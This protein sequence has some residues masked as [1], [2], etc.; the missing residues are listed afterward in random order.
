[1][2]LTPRTFG[3][4]I[5]FAQS[6]FR[7]YSSQAFA[8]LPITRTSARTS[9]SFSS[10]YSSS[11]SESSSKTMAPAVA[12]DPYLWLEDVES[13][14]SLAF[15]RDSNDK[16]LSQLGDPKTKTTYSKVLEILESD[17]RIAYVTKYGTN[18]DGEV[19]MY[20]LW[21]DSKN[22]K[23][24]LRKTTFD[25]YKTSSPKWETVLDIDQLAEQDGISW[26]YKG[27]TKLSRSIDPL[28]KS[29]GGESNLYTRSLM[30]LSR[31]GA[32]ATFIKEFDF[33][34]EQF[35]PSSEGGFTLP[36]A[37]TRASY[38]S[39]DVLYVGSDFGEG[40][41]TDSGYPRV[42]K[43]WTRGTK[44]EDAPVV[45]EGEKTDVSVS[46]Y[47][48]DQRF[49]GGRIYEIQ[50][51]SMTFYTTKKWVRRLEY[52]QLL[53][54]DDPARGGIA[55][56]ED[57]VEVDVQDDASVTFVGKRILISLRSDWE[58]VPGETVY[59]SGSLLDADA[60]TFL[61]QGNQAVTYSVLFEPT[62]RT[63]MEDYSFTKN[64]AIL[65][66]LDNV[67]AKLEFYKIGDDGFIYVG[68]D[69]EAHIRACSAGA[70][71]STEG[72]DIWLYTS[73]YTEPSGLS[74]GDASK[75]E[76]SAAASAE[77]VDATPNQQLSYHLEDLK[78]LPAMYDAS[79]LVA[80]QKIAKS[81][82]GTEIPYFI[83]SKKTLSSM[84]T[85]LHFCMDTE[86]LK[87]ALDPN[88][89]APLAYPGLNGEVSTSKPI[90]VAGANLDRVGT[91]RD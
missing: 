40:S 91:K 44:I 32:D 27:N 26:V 68:G 34:T 47:T 64:Y 3:T 13:E 11:A 18:E 59:K 14:E 4:F 79:D 21:K 86:G 87:S 19:I 62:E 43:E 72:D 51:R 70:I 89:L 49:R 41:L 82:D 22:P 69:K 67:K 1:M 2:K 58:P 66:I 16:C 54:K 15:A 81:K 74:L 25:S 30:S 77:V 33:L 73:G 57:F 23:G 45:F 42:I 80:N 36:E 63:A 55:Q 31:G 10:L 12:D 39:R 38:K 85:T 24:L 17:D 20:N 9:S 78:S 61:T 35:V 90:F 75:V 37:K 6:Y 8:L 71:D 83:I 60:D 50:A 65:S 5:A 76:D 88:I 28:S 46:M 52:E 53:A 84:E 56:L 48:N 7:F 29:Q